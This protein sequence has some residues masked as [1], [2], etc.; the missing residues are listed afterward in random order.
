MEVINDGYVLRHVLRE[1]AFYGLVQ[2]LRVPRVRSSFGLHFSTLF[3]GATERPNFH[4]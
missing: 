2:K 4:E 3:F 1:V